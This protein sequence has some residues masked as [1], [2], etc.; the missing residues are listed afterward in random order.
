MPVSTTDTAIRTR[1]RNE[2]ILLILVSSNLKLDAL[3]S[4]IWLSILRVQLIPTSRKTGEKGGKPGKH[5]PEM[6]ASG[7]QNWQRSETQG[8]STLHCHSPANDNVP[9]GMTQMVGRICRA[10][11]P[12]ASLRAGLLHPNQ[13]PPCFGCAQGR[14][15]TSQDHSQS[16]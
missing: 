4:Y 16:E 5:D 8:P 12:S 1:I 6:W 7:D 13:V 15:S 3:G 10:E 9:L 14:L 11:A 2:T